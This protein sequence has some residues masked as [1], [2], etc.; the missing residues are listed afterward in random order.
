MT[1][2][3]ADIVGQL[4]IARLPSARWSGALERFL[5]A[6]QPAGVLLS[7]PL[8]PSA[9]ATR[10]LL[11]RIA[12]TVRELPF[13]ALREEGGPED[14]LRQFLPSLPSPRAAAQKGLFAV[15]RLGELIGEG[16]GLLGFNTD[17]APLL[18]LATPLN[19][20]RL[21]ALNLLALLKKQIQS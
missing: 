17:F 7:P 4:L 3:R 20:E 18:D 6:T 13:L 10:E 15:A 11:H 5:L 8:P 19:K 12:G 9:E 16:L 21:E 2:S 14:P 1:L